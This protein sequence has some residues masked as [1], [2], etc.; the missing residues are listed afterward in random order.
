M[1][2]QNQMAPALRP[3]DVFN[4]A[5]R[6]L[7]DARIAQVLRAIA[8]ELAPPASP[9]PT[10]EQVSVAPTLM[11][12]PAPAAVVPESAP[13]VMAAEPEPAPVV[14]PLLLAA[15]PAPCEPEPA[16]KIPRRFYSRTTRKT[17]VRADGN[18]AELWATNQWYHYAKKTFPG[19]EGEEIDGGRCCDL[20]LT[21]NEVAILKHHFSRRKRQQTP[22]N[23]K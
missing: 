7:I 3:T 5:Q 11:L 18:L 14:I 22:K 23:G 20:W 17:R 21:P 2:D 1:T 13:V 16:P 4:A 10:N 19:F 15:S 6:L 9:A 8:D 12:T